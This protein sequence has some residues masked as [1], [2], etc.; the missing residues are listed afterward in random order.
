MYNPVERS[1]VVNLCSIDFTHLVCYTLIDSS[2]DRRDVKTVNIILCD[3]E[4][5]FLTSIEQ[6]I[7]QWAQGKAHSGCIEIH[8]F[9]SSE[10]L[11]DAWEHGLQ[12][13]VLF[14]DIQIPGE[15]SGLALAK[16]I[17][18]MN[19]YIPIVFITS[20]GEYAEAGYT[21]NVLRYLRKPVTEH[22]IA[23]CMDIIWRRWT[24]LHENCVTFDLPNQVL[25][26]PAETI[27]YTEV[28]GHTCSIYTID[29]E[30]PYR[31]RQKMDY[32]LHKLPKGL[33]VQCHRSYIVNLK[34][35]HQLTNSSL[36]MSDGMNISIGRTYQKE[37]MKQF[38]CFY[39]GRS[40]LK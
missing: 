16:E 39:V 35:V 19:E 40:E 5:L 26:L 4:K 24:L 34:Y 6:K 36:T 3:D 27:L 13:D 33:F 18:K 23:E 28:T 17:R 25:I 21:V 37:F 8:S 22:A 31:I 15:M 14:L 29:R 38:R 10:D 1:H 11:L 7:R 12:A 30:Q 32:L 2:N 20:Y 9:T